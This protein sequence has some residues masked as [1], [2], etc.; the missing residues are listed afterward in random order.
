[1][2]KKTLNGVETPNLKMKLCISKLYHSLERPL[3]NTT[4]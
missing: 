1:M 3:S 2:G 4:T